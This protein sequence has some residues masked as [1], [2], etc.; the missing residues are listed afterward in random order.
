MKKQ[1]LIFDMSNPKKYLSRVVKQKKVIHSLV[2]IGIV[3]FMCG[4]L[5][6]SE[7]TQNAKTPPL[8][9]S[10]TGS[11]PQPTKETLVL[12]A[13]RICD[14]DLQALD[15]LRFTIEN[16]YR[17]PETP[18]TPESLSD[19]CALG[20][21]AFDMLG[22]ETAKGCAPAFEALKSCLHTEFVDHFAIK[23]MGIAAAGGHK[24]SLSILLSQANKTILLSEA[25]DALNDPASE[26]IEPAVDYLIKVIDTPEDSPLHQMAS[27]GLVGAAQK[28]NSKAQATL[29]KLIRN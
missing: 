15:T 21:A 18:E 16:L 25:V 20:R 23:G 19:K 1:F 5:L 4:I 9:I 10:S 11:K 13:K 17:R 8:M 7:E 22:I 2:F 27:E 26:N 14:G 29:A 28:G 6:A 12:L 24:E 3:F